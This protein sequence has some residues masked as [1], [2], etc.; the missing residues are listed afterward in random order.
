MTMNEVYPTGY[1]TW[2]W[3]VG[4]FNGKIT[5]LGP[6][7]TDDDARSSGLEKFDHIIDIHKLPTRDESKATRMVKALMLREKGYSAEEA[8]S[9]MHH[10]IMEGSKVPMDNEL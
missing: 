3:V 1:G 7:N 8:L 9:K 6:F 2:H 4:S 5:L 10:T